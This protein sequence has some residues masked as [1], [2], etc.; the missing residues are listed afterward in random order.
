MAGRVWPVDTAVE[1][2][3]PEQLDDA[4]DMDESPA[5]LPKKKSEYPPIPLYSLW[6]HANAL[7]VLLIIIASIASMASGIINPLA[8]KSIG[9]MIASFFTWDVSNLGLGTSEI[10]QKGQ[11][12]G[13]LALGAFVSTYLSRALWVFTAERQIKRI[14]LRYLQSVLQRDM[15]W[16]DVLQGESLTA[17]LQNDVPLIRGG[18]GEN[19]G[20]FFHFMGTLIACLIIGF[21]TQWKLCLIM[22]ALMPLLILDGYLIVKVEAA[23]SKKSSD[24]Y[25]QASSVAE[26]ALSGIRTVDA[27]S[28]QG[29]FIAK[30]E[31]ALQQVME[32]DMRKAKWS[33]FV[34][35]S[36]TFLMLCI[37][38]FGLW[39]GS[40]LVARGEIR[41]TDTVV[42]VLDMMVLA[43]ALMSVPNTLANFARAKAG[44][45]V[46]YNLISTMS[47]SSS[48][49]GTGHTNLPTAR[50]DISFNKVHF[51]YP[52]R[53]DAPVLSG[54]TI[55]I[56]AGQTVAFV[57]ESGSGKSTTI[58]LLQRFY[59]PSQGTI[60]LDGHDIQ[61]LTVSS[62]RSHI[63]LVGQEPVLFALTIK[64]NILLGCKGEITPARFIE[65]CKLAQ[66]HDFIC[67]FP[68][69]YDTPV[70]EGLLS[71]GQKQR[72]AIARALIK[73]PKILLLDEATS[74]LD[75]QSERL[76]QKALDTA[77]EGRTTIIIA[78][79]LSTVRNAD[80]ICVMRNGHIIEKGTHDTLYARNGLY[81]QLVNRQKLSTQSSSTQPLY[82][83]V[84]DDAS[85]TATKQP[86]LLTNVQVREMMNHPTLV[87]ESA[88]VIAKQVRLRMKEESLRRKED[89]VGRGSFWKMYGRVRGMMKN[90]G[91]AIRWGTTGSACSGMVFPGFA[92]ILGLTISP[93][94]TPGPNQ[95]AKTNNWIRYM[96]KAPPSPNFSEVL[97]SNHP[98]TPQPL[99]GLAVLGLISKFGQISAF[100]RANARLATRLRSAVFAN[101]LR[102]EIGYFD[103]KSNGVGV[104]TNKLAMVEG[105][106]HLVT[107]VRRELS[108]M[109]FTIIF[110]IAPAFAFSIGM[111]GVMLG[112]APFIIAAS[113][114]QSTSL[115]R[116]AE[117]S[118]E[119]IEQ[120]T[121][122][123]IESIREVKTL[124]A[125]VREDFAVKRY[126]AFLS[127]PFRLSRRNAFLD[128]LAYAVQAAASM[129]TVCVGLTAGAW[130]MD[131]SGLSLAN[132]LTA[133]MG[134]L[135]SMLSIASSAGLATAY[136]KAKFAVLT[137]FA[138]LD[139]T[140]HIDPNK[141][142][143]VPPMFNSGFQ[144]KDLQFCYPTS[145]EPIFT[146]GFSLHG[147][148]NKS[149][150]LVG[151]SGCGK[152]TV[153][154]L[155]QRWYDPTG[156]TATVGGIPIS[157]YDILRGL[158]VNMALVGQEPIL[159]DLT[160]SEN[161]AWGSEGM[162]SL[163]DIIE[164]AKMANAHGF[165]TALPEGYQTRVGQKGGR[166]SGGQKQRIAIARAMIRKP[167]LLLLD[168]ATSALDSASEVEVQKAIDWAAVGRTTVTIAHRLSTIKN[169]DAIA[170]VNEGRVVEF[171]GHEE[172]LR[173]EG[174]YAA[175][176]RQQDL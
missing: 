38:A 105:V 74:A 132:M 93:I 97:S 9:L 12:F 167:K 148:A 152:S 67:K 60:T 120:A 30:Y 101:M 169:V 4:P 10:R 43:S 8:I 140:P 89:V 176:C 133:I 141:P 113:Y 85:P 70:A 155:L 90:E 170:V 144:F 48:A 77:S 106:P 95:E 86:D 5:L 82:P 131:T 46:I 25:S 157:E 3:M 76:V 122:V 108:Q 129:L 79:R 162:V 128:S 135:V 72:V 134:M 160:I 94:M 127:K 64:Q 62:L 119:A 24:A 156:G 17:R 171:G 18:I 111:T 87:L 61:S 36:F 39:L 99:A 104:L 52:A 84:Q 92:M 168:E 110:G 34:L 37:F 51:S 45:Q 146:G 166:L 63:G 115:S 125:L 174:V 33:G 50:G 16:F 41:A 117:V 151:P 23:M 13:L 44:A 22:L 161:I 121:Q 21:T 123:A 150:A 142:G 116:F 54:L 165:I 73:D 147:E 19:T 2:D 53:P 57:G 14:S 69:G 153:I 49:A 15:G 40:R 143:V 7:D 114:W 138:I 102:Q 118:K 31:D 26:Q 1:I 154:G 32:A 59:S 103:A 145:P 88:E 100:G 6:R 98:P 139:R 66:C 11:I 172:L 20:S 55:E 175:M 78:H 81:T 80:I 83:P 56:R 75:T 173:L 109:G 47:T 91:S 27:F 28:L 163:E 126:E 159:F 130:L 68:L 107:D 65:V 29:R 58:G 112:L 42:V 136:A 158:R 137:T 96:R 71:G 149:L 35:G 124:K 164:A